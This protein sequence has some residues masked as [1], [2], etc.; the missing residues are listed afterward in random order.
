MSTPAR[1]WQFSLREFLIA[2]TVLALACGFAVILPLQISVLLVGLIWIV[3]TSL[4]IIGLIFGQGDRRAFCIGAL[5]VVSA[6]WTGI[7]G[8]F[9][10]GVHSFIGMSSATQSLRHWLDLAVLAVVAVANGRLC[11]KARAYFESE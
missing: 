4:L 8:L 11:V 10:H 5:V 3:A 6:M 9:M 7:G 1:R 2:T